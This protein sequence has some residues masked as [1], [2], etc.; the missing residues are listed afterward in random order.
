MSE[1]IADAIREVL[2]DYKN[3][4]RAR[5]RMGDVMRL[6]YRVADAIDSTTTD[7]PGG[8]ESTED[9]PF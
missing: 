2:S 5:I 9:K 7:E 4:D 8:E 3:V 1:K 6:L